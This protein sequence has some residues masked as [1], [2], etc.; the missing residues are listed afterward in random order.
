MWKE[1]ALTFTECKSVWHP[2]KKSLEDR[3]V[4]IAF[5]RGGPI[6]SPPR[7]ALSLLLADIAWFEG[8]VGWFTLLCGYLG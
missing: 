7:P 2:G 6:I 3:N 8:G 5:G 4:A 1:R